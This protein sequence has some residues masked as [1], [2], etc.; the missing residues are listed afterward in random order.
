MIIAGVLGMTGQCYAL[1]GYPPDWEHWK[2]KNGKNNASN[3]ASNVAAIGNDKGA[4]NSTN[5][6]TVGNGVETGNTFGMK[7]K[8]LVVSDGL[9]G[10]L[11][12]L[13]HEHHTRLL[14]FFGGTSSS[15][16]SNDHLSGPSL[17]EID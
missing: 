5:G 11:P 2:H 6:T 13:T 1:F 16:N 14:A 15:S 8:A 7:Q 10:P 3:A 17:D 9:M 4:V 12:S